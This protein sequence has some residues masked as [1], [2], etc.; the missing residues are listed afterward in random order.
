VTQQILATIHFKMRNFRY[1][2]ARGQFRKWLRTVTHNA[3]NDFLNRDESKRYR[4]FLGDVEAQTRLDHEIDEQAKD[5]LL[6]AAMKV[7][8]GQVSE[9][10]WLI[11][12]SLYFDDVKGPSLAK[13]HGI[14]L[15]AVHM[16]A[17][18]IRKRLKQM[19]EILGGSDETSGEDE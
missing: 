6:G 1:N 2:P 18:R 16:I 9:R 17:S 7:V 13:E 14:S 4:Q 10:D 5:E 12:N 15:A 8:R 3:C 19:M 11:F